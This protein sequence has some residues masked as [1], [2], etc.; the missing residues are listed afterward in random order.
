MC[1]C[2]SLAQVSNFPLRQLLN[3]AAWVAEFRL[4]KAAGLSVMV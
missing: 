4:L 3:L 1:A 2:C